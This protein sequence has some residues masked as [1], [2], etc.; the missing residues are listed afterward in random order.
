MSDQFLDNDDKF[1]IS[2]EPKVSSGRK[3][4]KIPSALSSLIN[5][6]EERKGILN[7][8]LNQKNSFVV[9]NE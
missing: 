1:H 3:C 8:S 2:Y 4:F 7:N 5:Y 9:C 6:G